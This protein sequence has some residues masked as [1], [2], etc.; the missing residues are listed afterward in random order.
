MVWLLLG[1]LP[2][3]DW[4]KRYLQQASWTRPLR[5]YLLKQAGLQNARRVLEVGCGTGVILRDVAQSARGSRVDVLG[6]HGLDLRHEILLDAKQY[7]PSAVL[8]CGDAHILPYASGT[9]DI[10]FCHF[11][12]LWA[13]NPRTALQEMRRVTR[14]GGRVVAFAEP[15]Y[16]QRVDYP[17]EL[18]LLG[19]WQQDAL[20]EQGADPSLGSHLADLFFQAGLQII[21]TGPLAP[22]QPDL[23]GEA[24]WDDEWCV[25]QHDLCGQVS[26]KELLRL[27]ELDRSAR[28]QGKRILQVPTYF[29]LAQV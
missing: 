27:Q 6:V 10:T 3:M 25:L 16:D 11:L 4:H 15:A 19:K 21:E 17:D 28:Q 26:D 18:A 12:L 2:S 24:V 23:H 5:E 20:K 8:A 13:A 22:W 7:V 14:Q 29:A 1:N 9:F